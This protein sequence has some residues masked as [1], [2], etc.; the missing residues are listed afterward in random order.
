MTSLFFFTLILASQGLLW[1]HMKF[2]I[3]ISVK[4]TESI[5]GFEQNGQLNNINFFLTHEHGTLSISLSS[6]TAFIKISQFTMYRSFT[7]L[8]LENFISQYFIVFDAIQN[9]VDLFFSDVLL[10]VI[11]MQLISES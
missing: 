10:L 1:F 5:D 2:R 3:S 4:R 11:E 7:H 9:G 8:I 6:S